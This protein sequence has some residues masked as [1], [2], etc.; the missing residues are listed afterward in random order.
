MRGNYSE[1]LILLQLPLSP[2]ASGESIK[3]AGPQ[4]RTVPS[5]EAEAISPG[6]VGFQLTQL[7]VRV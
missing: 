3:G 5:S 1:L 6:I 4:M 7:T 2:S